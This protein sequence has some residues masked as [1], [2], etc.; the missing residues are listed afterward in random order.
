M[1]NKYISE[2]QHYCFTKSTVWFWKKAVYT[3]KQLTSKFL[4][5]YMASIFLPKQKSRF[6]EIEIFPFNALL[7]SFHILMFISKKMTSVMDQPAR[8]ISVCLV[9]LVCCYLVI[10]CF[11]SVVAVVFLR[12]LTADECFFKVTLPGTIVIL[13]I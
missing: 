13:V 11:I 1:S 9:F 8:H 7:D 12:L 6:S 4:Y 2:F 3:P 10:L 5:Q